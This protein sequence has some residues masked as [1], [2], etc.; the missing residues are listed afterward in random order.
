MGVSKTIQLRDVPDSLHRQLKARAA[1][2]GMPL[3]KYLLLEIKEI[4]E[5]PT[6][7]EMR[8]RLGQRKP[9]SAQFDAAGVLHEERDARGASLARQQK[10][11]RPK[12]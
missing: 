5:R 7:A 6:L 12:S 9:V 8:D 11:I 1:S 4:A 3:S 2:A 10:R